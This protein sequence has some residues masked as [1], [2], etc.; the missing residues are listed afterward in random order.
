M[1]LSP[2]RLESI[3]HETGIRV[4]GGICRS[5]VLIE[6]V[7]SS[8]KLSARKFKG[9]S[10]LENQAIESSRE[11]CRLLIH[12]VNFPTEDCVERMAGRVDAER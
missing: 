9:D 2:K 7:L 8:C 11:D 12:Y 6:D 1:I 10:D 3:V 4:K 5:T